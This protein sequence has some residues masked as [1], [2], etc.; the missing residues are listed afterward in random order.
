[1][2]TK[3]KINSGITLVALVITIVVLLI[4]A[5]IT[6]MTLKETSLL[7]NT[8]LAKNEMENAQNLE[9]STIDGYENKI[10]EIVVGTTR[11]NSQSTTDD[12]LWDGVADTVDQEYTL[13]KP[14]NNYKRLIFYS[15]LSTNHGVK[16]NISSMVMETEDIKFPGDTGYVGLQFIISGGFNTSTM[17]SF[18]ITFT[19]TDKFKIQSKSIQG[20]AS[21]AYARIYKVI[22]IK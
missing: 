2:K 10:N 8:K 11:E 1:M 20:W 15:A 7:K 9:K 12:I 3:E 21:S 6:I 17:Y 22:G 16:Q 18:R 19:D 4:L 5:G 14:V 13:N